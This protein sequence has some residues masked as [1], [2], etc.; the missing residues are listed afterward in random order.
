MG[1]PDQNF[2]QSSN[3]ESNDEGMTTLASLNNPVVPSDHLSMAPPQT[4]REIKK[5]LP[6]KNTAKGMRSQEYEVIDD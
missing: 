5:N 1:T 6:I 2:P 3:R 4:D